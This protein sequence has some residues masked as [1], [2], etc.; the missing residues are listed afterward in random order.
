MFDVDPSGSLR[1]LALHTA[2]KITKL[3]KPHLV[4]YQASHLEELASLL[5][6]ILTRSRRPETDGVIGVLAED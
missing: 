5:R 1:Q 2:N 6:G 3:S 4:V